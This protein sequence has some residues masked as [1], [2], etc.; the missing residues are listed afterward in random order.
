MTARHAVE[1]IRSEPVPVAV[2]V[3]TEDAGAVRRS[4]LTV[5]CRDLEVRRLIA[6]VWLEVD[7]LEAPV[8]IDRVVG[9]PGE[10]RSLP[11]GYRAMRVRLEEGVLVGAELR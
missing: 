3:E 7:V 2:A 8:R 9:Q 4:Q 6:G 5:R 11:L 1:G 10:G